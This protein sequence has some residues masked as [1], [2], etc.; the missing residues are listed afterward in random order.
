[1]GLRYWV[2]QSCKNGQL[3][4]DTKP[5]RCPDCGKVGGGWKSS[6]VTKMCSFRTYE[7][8]YCGRTVE[9]RRPP[10]YPCDVCGNW[11][12]RVFKCL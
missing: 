2:C 5:T 11:S 8:S 10:T 7:C 1:M 12:W 4:S 6:D 9:E 3:V